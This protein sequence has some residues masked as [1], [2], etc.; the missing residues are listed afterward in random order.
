MEDG[1]IFLCLFPIRNVAVIYL[2]FILGFLFLI[3]GAGLMVDGAS[4]I[5]RRLQVSDLVIGLTVVAFGTSAPEMF[6]NLMAS[7]QGN[8]D[9]AIGNILGSNIAN[10]LLILGVCALIYPISIKRN[11]I[12][13]EIP[14]SLLAA[15]ALGLLANDALI[16]KKQLSELTRIDGAI[17]LC[18]FSIFLYYV[19][20]IARKTKEEEPLSTTKQMPLP[21]AIV[22]VVVGVTGLVVGGH[23]IVQGAIH[24]A[25]AFGVSEALIGLTVVAV[26]TSLPELATSAVAAYKK[27]TD[28]AIGNVV[29]SNIFNV[30]WV[31]GLSS[32]I[33]P[34]PF[35]TD[36]NVDI[37]M[38]IFSSL[39]LFIFG[40]V[41]KQHLLTR[42]KGVFFL[43]AYVLY[44]L[45]LIWRG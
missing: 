12:Y 41:G 39:L 32:V 13:K 36:S 1:T 26:G 30:F 8:T 44:T 42:A 24:L 14:F 23:W 11:T 20:E 34:L 45:Y 37:L 2:L 28:I 6:V 22:F 16:D 3:K 25:E 38:V 31:L 29:G 21:K 5:A 35:S 15:I 18:F 19:F 4:S 10:I 40:F 17:L 7:Y 33:R 27:N 43:A 9:I